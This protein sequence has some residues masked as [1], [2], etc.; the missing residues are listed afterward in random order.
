M[1]LKAF[2]FLFILFS[3][4]SISLHPSESSTSINASSSTYLHL[5]VLQTLCF[6]LALGFSVSAPLWLSQEHV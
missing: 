1:G 6:L 4:I 5:V 2:S 3:H